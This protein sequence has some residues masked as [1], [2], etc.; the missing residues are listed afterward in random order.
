[1]L[2]IQ[3]LMLDVLR[4]LRPLLAAM[5]SVDPNLADQTRRAAT[6]MVLN[7]AEA[8]G[9]QGGNVRARYCT[10]LGSA[11]ELSAC[12]DCALA[13]GYVESVSNEVLVKLNRVIGGL[14]R[15][16]RR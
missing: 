12:L 4:G 2:D 16:S 11:R 8:R 9:S 3:H 6:S 5:K 14:V 10:A 15:L 13:L 1:M 7:T